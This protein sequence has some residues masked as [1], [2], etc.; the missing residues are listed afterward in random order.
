MSVQ[1]SSAE[2]TLLDK[3]SFKSAIVDFC[4]GM[5]EKKK[6]FR[7]MDYFLY[8]FSQSMLMAFNRLILHR[9]RDVCKHILV[10]I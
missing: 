6:A 8:I 1:P 2:E 9:A 10:Y 3:V 7:S 4:S 5:Q